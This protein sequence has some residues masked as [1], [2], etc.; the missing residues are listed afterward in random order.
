MP[1]RRTL[2]AL[3]GTAAVS[4]AALPPALAA[5]TMLVKQGAL[6]GESGHAATGT[7]QIVEN[8]G[9]YYVT[10]AGDFTFDG[11]P[12]AKVALG[13]DGYDKATLMGALKSNAGAQS[14][15]I[16]AGIDPAAYNEVWIWCEQYNVPLGMA[17]LG[18]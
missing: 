13:H 12:D 18:N 16:P 14:Y 4:L 2:I 10:L 6:A 3:L 7:A 17:K 5:D 11:A 8:G 1:D 15:P 9:T